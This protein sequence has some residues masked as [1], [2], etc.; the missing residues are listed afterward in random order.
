MENLY[1][2]R[3]VTEECGV[4][5]VS[6]ATQTHQTF[7]ATCNI[8]LFH[9]CNNALTFSSKITGFLQEKEEISG[10]RGVFLSLQGWWGTRPWWAYPVALLHVP[11]VL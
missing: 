5:K 1:L 6:G 4:L 2:A 9:M 7:P 10:F 3:P 11:W 8:R